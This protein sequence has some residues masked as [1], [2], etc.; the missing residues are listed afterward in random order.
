MNLFANARKTAH[1]S[2]RTFLHTLGLGGMFFTVRGAFAD[3]LVQT[4]AQTEGPYYP[5]HL[6]LD[7]DND[8]LIINDSIT[9]AVG[10]ISWL[11]GRVLDS[12]GSPIRGAVVEIWQADD[13]G[14]YI[15]SRSPIANRDVNFQGYGKF[16][17]ASSGE[18]L[19]RTVKPGLYPG[20]TRHV[21][22]A[23]NVPGRSKLTTQ[24]YVQGETLN[25]SDGVLNGIR[26]TA[27]RNS[28]VVPWAAIESS[29]IGELAARFD[30]VMGLTPEDS[31]AGPK[32]TIAKRSAVVNG[33]AFQQGVAP[34]AWTAIFGD[35]LASTTRTWSDADIVD[36]KLPASLDGVSVTINNK[37]A[38]VQFIS[39]QQINVQAPSDDTTGSVQVMVTTSGGASDPVS[40]TMQPLLPGLFRVEQDYVKAVRSDGVSI[41]TTVPAKPG[42]TV[43]LFG[44]GFGPTSP[45]VPTGEAF[46][47]TAD[48]SNAVTISIGTAKADVM[49]AG[50]TGPGMYQFNVVIPDLPD[51]DYPVTATVGGVRTQSVARL[52]IQR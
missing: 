42:D 47:G 24:L 27:A 50:L 17:T 6:P 51:G 23:I 41:D 10:A 20:R 44:T 19:F 45:A 21:H 13:H 30:I 7:Q 12:T 35:N 2:R 18:Y 32:P 43:A 15:H 8:L 33:A 28:V 1:P 5:D 39:P 25:G 31:P 46:Q 14:A 29:R 22:M 26:D 37:P 16:E 34:G 49:F 36:G 4:P 40:A 38:A 3:A 48:L 52:R 9:P 11:S